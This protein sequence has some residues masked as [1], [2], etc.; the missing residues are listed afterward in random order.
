M[1]I[2]SQ[3]FSSPSHDDTFV[4]VPVVPVAKTLPFQMEMSYYLEKGWNIKDLCNLDNF[5]KAFMSQSALFWIEKQAEKEK[6][7]FGEK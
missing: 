6:A 7:M 3:T 2:T 1:N 4:S 5:E